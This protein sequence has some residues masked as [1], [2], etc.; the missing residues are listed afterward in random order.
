[1]EDSVTRKH[2]LELFSCRIVSG[3]KLNMSAEE[4]LTRVEHLISP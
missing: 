2:I 1:M 3:I 4:I